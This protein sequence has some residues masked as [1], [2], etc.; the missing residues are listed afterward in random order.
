[1]QTIA[2]IQI[3]KQLIL[4]TQFLGKDILKG[5][6]RKEDILEKFAIS[7][8]KDI[9]TR[10]HPPLDVRTT[11]VSAARVFSQEEERDSLKCNTVIKDSERKKPWSAN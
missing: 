7:S 4:N 1:M 3:V 11:F 2:T 5:E 10:L 8:K 9:F 6:K